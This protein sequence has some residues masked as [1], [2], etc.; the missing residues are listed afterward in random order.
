MMTEKAFE[1]IL[2]NLDKK[3]ASSELMISHLTDNVYYGLLWKYNLQI[4]KTHSSLSPKKLYLIQNDSGKWASIVYDSGSDLHWYTLKGNRSKGILFRALQNYILPHIFQMRKAKEI[5]VSID[6]EI[7]EYKASKN[8]ALN[9]G[10]KA[11]DVPDSP[12]I[13]RKL[14]P[15]RLKKIPQIGNKVMLENAL[16]ISRLIT[17]YIQLLKCLCQSTTRATEACKVLPPIEKKMNSLKDTI[18]DLIWDEEQK[19]PQS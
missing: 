2:S 8:L 11:S 4:L 6:P 10:F 16:E 19:T 7:P 1:E 18:D 14:R 12:E 3:N 9:L 15:Q 5:T 17:N 13:Y